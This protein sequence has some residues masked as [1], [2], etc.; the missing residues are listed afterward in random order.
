MVQPLDILGMKI[1]PSM[2]RYG[3]IFSPYYL[4]FLNVLEGKMSKD[5]FYSFSRGG[6]GSPKLSLFI[7]SLRYG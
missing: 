6:C 5:K 2:R 3:R 4:F 1:E 7:I